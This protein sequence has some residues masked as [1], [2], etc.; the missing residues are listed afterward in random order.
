MIRDGVVE[1]VS[2]WD[3]DLAKWQ[4]PEGIVCIPAPDDIGIGWTWDGAN[5]GSIVAPTDSPN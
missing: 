1:N 3:G 2:L 4:P 5:W